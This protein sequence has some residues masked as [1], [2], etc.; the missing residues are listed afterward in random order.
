MD[1]LPS[2]DGFRMP[3]EWHP[4]S[5][6]WMG[7]P[8]RPDNWRNNAGPAQEAFARVVSAIMQFEPVTVCAPDVSKVHTA[9]GPSDDSA[10]TVPAATEI[11]HMEQDD[12]WFRDC[13]PTFLLRERPGE[14]GKQ[15]LAGVDWIFNAWGGENGGLYKSW[16]KDQKVASLIL[17]RAGALRYKCPHVLEGG[18]IHVDSEG[19][20]MTTEECLLNP[21]RNPDLGK[22]Q[23]EE[24]LKGY[25]GVS[26]V[27]WLPKGLYKDTDTNGHVDNFACF[28]RPGVVLLAW[29]DDTQDPQHAISAEALQYLESQTDAKGRRLEVIKMPLPPPLHISEEESAGVAKVDGSAPREAGERLAASYVN[30][31]LPNGGVIAPQFGGEAAEADARALEVFRSAFP[32]RKVVGVQTREVLLGGGN[33]HCI[34]QQQPSLDTVPS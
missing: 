22:E 3:A 15:E 16:D 23:I 29:T 33:I 8:R 17:E 12:S 7:W 34:T 20:V 19:T 13:G 28:A 9:V 26:K 6:C 24:F 30:F 5:M 32:G 31:Y 25:L 4:H 27:L 10:N 2:R 11:I 18:S 14:A 1:S 21:N